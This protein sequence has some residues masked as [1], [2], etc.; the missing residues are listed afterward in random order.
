MSSLSELISQKRASRAVASW[1]QKVVEK[2]ASA[3]PLSSS[4]S[5]S[6]VL[7][8][9]PVAKRQRVPSP[10]KRRV[11]ASAG[12]EKDS[13]AQHLRQAVAALRAMREPARVFGE[14][15][16]QVI[17]RLGL[18]ESPLAAAS[19]ISRT[20]P[21]GPDGINPVGFDLASAEIS[22]MK[23]AKIFSAADAETRIR[24][25]LDQVFPSPA[26]STTSG[27]GGEGEG[28]TKRVL[29]YLEW[30][31]RAWQETLRERLRRKGHD[32]GEEEGERLPTTALANQERVENFLA[33]V[34]NLGFMVNGL[35]GGTVPDKLVGWLERIVGLLEQRR[36]REATAAYMEVAI[37]NATWPIGA[38]MVGIH[39]RASRNKLFSDKV[40][41]VLDNEQ[42]KKAIHAVKGLITFASALDKKRG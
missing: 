8:E 4:S 2:R 23:R 38:T 12:G 17:K 28:V 41:H 1:Q 40:R 31:C 15:D 11:V 35:R 6:A 25:R 14:T 5:S 42:Q 27:E 3:P 32:G 21:P 16:E 36:F 18:L 19:G 37:G 24:E 33:T 26:S 29:G 7:E 20:D 39:E 10:E 9:E 13:E 22:E 34:G 30:L